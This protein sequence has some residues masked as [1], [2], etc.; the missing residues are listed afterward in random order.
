[1]CLPK[2][3]NFSPRLARFGVKRLVR[4]VFGIGGQVELDPKAQ[5]RRIILNQANHS[6]HWLLAAL[7]TLASAADVAVSLGE[8]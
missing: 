8:T 5:I 6:A 2:R 7:Q 1:V 3:R 4:D